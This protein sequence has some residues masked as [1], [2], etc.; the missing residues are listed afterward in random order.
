MNAIFD[1]FS[2]R[3]SGLDRFETNKN[4]INKF[5]PN[6]NHINLSKAYELID[7]LTSSALKEPVVLV[8]TDSDK[9]IIAGAKS[10]TVFGDINPLAISRAKSYIYSDKVVFYSQHQDDE[11]L[12]S[13][14][15]IIDAIESVGAENVYVVLISDGDESGVFSNPR[16]SNLILEKKTALRNNE[17]K[18]AVSRL[19]VLE[20]NLVLLNQPEKNINKNIIIKTMLDFENRFDNITHVSHSY[21]YDLHE[22]HLATGNILYDLYKSKKIKD[23]RFFARKELIPNYNNKLLIQSTSDNLNEKSKILKACYEYKLDNGDM[24]R[25]GIGYK[26]VGS[27]FNDLTSDPLN[28]SYLHEPGL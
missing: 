19:G 13:G 10:L 5:F 8:D 24:I 27:L 9:S 11:T 14:S 2:E 20:Q 3:I 17:F 6:K 1:K 26:S 18:A 25:E 7:A 21:K 28:I 15:A 16:Y 23:C 12:F 4:V 22:Q